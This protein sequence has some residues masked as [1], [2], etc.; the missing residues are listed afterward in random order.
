MKRT[1]GVFH[2]EIL[3]IGSKC[4][5]NIDDEHQYPAYIQDMQPDKGP[6]NVFV[7]VLGQRYRIGLI[8]IVSINLSF[9]YFGYIFALNYSPI[10]NILKWCCRCTVPYDRIE[11]IVLPLALSKTRCLCINGSSTTAT[12]A[13]TATAAT[14]AVQQALRFR[15]R[16]RTITSSN[17]FGSSATEKSIRDV[18]V[19]ASV[20]KFHRRTTTTSA[21]AAAAANNKLALSPMDLNNN[22]LARFHLNNYRTFDWNTFTKFFM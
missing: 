13:S 16:C 20:D 3:Q 19:S 7:E 4:L 12:A 18:V 11:P 6:V 8:L 15:S 17:R 21:A 5:V 1:S 22:Q 14:T 10:A 2:N 9:I